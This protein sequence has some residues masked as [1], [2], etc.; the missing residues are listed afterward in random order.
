MITTFENRCVLKCCV[1]VLRP[2]FNTTYKGDIKVEIYMR[3]LY[4]ELVLFQQSR[5]FF[6]YVPENE[7]KEEILGW[8]PCKDKIEHYDHTEYKKIYTMIR[9]KNCI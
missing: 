5:N 4:H 6:R 3:A 1:I 8:N 2:I 9:N 7:T